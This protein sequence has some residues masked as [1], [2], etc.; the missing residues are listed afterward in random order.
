MLAESIRQVVPAPQIRHM[1][2][3]VTDGQ[4][5]QVLLAESDGAELLVVGGRGRGGF[6]GMLL[7]STSQHVLSHASCPVVV[8][9]ATTTADLALPINSRTTR[10]PGR[11]LSRRKHWHWTAHRDDR[12]RTSSTAQCCCAPGDS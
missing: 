5:A 10:I 11:Y 3:H 7:G 6:T 4:P 1:Y 8:H 12:T 9:N 2:K